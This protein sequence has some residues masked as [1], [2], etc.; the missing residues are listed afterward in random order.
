MLKISESGGYTLCPVAFSFSKNSF[1]W[2]KY[3]WLNSSCKADSHDGSIWGETVVMGKMHGM[4]AIVIIS[5][6]LCNPN[7]K[8]I[9]LIIK[10]E[11]MRYF[12]FRLV[13]LMFCIGTCLSANGQYFFSQDC[14]GA[15]SLCNGRY[16][17][18]YS[19]DGNGAIDELALLPTCLPRSEG[20]SAWYRLAIDAPGFLALS[21]EPL[22]PNDD[23]DFAIF[24][25]TGLNCANIM[26]TTA[27][28]VRCSYAN[29]MGEATGLS[30]TDTLT[31]AGENDEPF[32]Y[33]LPVDSGDVFALLVTS[34]SPF[35]YGYTLDLTASTATI[36]SREPLQ[37]VDKV[38]A[39]CE[40]YLYAELYFNQPID[41]NSL[42]GNFS[43]LSITDNV[44][45]NITVTRVSFDSIAN[46]LA[47]IG[48]KPNYT[49]DSVVLRYQLGADANTIQSA[50]NNQYLAV[51]LDSFN[52]L[53]NNIRA[54]GF[55]ATNIGRR[56]SMQANTVNV[57]MVSWYINGN[58][59]V[60]Q[61]ASMPFVSN[62]TAGQSYKVCM[63]AELGCNYDSTC[64]V[65]MYTSIDDLVSD[66]PISLFPNPV[67][68]IVTIEAPFEIERLELM[69]LNGKEVQ[70][71]QVSASIVNLQLGMVPQ[72]VYFVM[73]YSKGTLYSKRVVVM[74]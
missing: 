41:S 53:F 58:L 59:V 29:S 37:I 13:I 54:G 36:V 48:V 63:V 10:K 14:S 69:D 46:K 15:L 2:A 20:N 6:G 11:R 45:G 4:R 47:I 25:I 35:G 8:H 44:G 40:D 66:A 68:D 5:R 17:F 61:Q 16:V 51:G 50:C 24:D 56:F 60:R 43:E 22:G 19:F 18:P 74:H 49:I 55:T 1:I 28:I 21:I 73:V 27:A 12:N 33:W 71:L 34:S 32:L 39:I 38:M 23:Y 52:Y 70:K 31:S 65:L 9:C 57:P 72:G 62:F 67:K 26:D 7:D 30:S 64:Q 42:S 3:G